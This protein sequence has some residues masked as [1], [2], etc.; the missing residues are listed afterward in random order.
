MIG[1]L[2]GEFLLVVLVVLLNVI[3]S[4]LLLLGQ[5]LAHS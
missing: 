2:L 5:L 4:N 1:R 3:L